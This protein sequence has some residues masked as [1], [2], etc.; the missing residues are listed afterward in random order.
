[1]RESEEEEK[2]GREE[3][4]DIGREIMKFKWKEGKAKFTPNG[5][6]SEFIDLLWPYTFDEMINCLALSDFCSVTI[7][8]L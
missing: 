6:V 4:E 5:A 8:L 7:V 2:G 1:M 3:G